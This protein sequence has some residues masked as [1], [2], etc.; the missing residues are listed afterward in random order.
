M[1]TWCWF[2][3]TCTNI[4]YILYLFQINE[5]KKKHFK[6]PWTSFFV[7]ICSYFSCKSFRI[8][9]S[10]NNH[11]NIQNEYILSPK[12]WFLWKYLGTWVFPV[13]IISIQ[14]I[15]F[16]NVSLPLFS[17]P[18]CKPIIYPLKT[19]PNQSR[20]KTTNYNGWPNVIYRC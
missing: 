18:P 17:F 3:S 14:V 12:T 11:R 6:T 13:H 19:M 5:Q 4:V 2:I 15:S 8:K 1:C 20:L 16:W 10:K 9:F 7:R